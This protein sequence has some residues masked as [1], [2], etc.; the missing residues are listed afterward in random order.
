MEENLPQPQTPVNP[1]QIPVPPAEPP[2][3]QPIPK[4]SFPLKWILIIV[5]LAEIV[6]AGIYLIFKSQ[7][8]KQ[9]PVQAPTQIP[10][11]SFSPAP[12]DKTSNWK[13]Y[14]NNKYQFSISYPENLS[15]KEE[16]HDFLGSQ[17]YFLDE[18]E[19]TP[20]GIKVSAIVYDKALGK[21]IDQDFDTL[22]AL[23]P[24]TSKTITNSVVG[25]NK[26][27]KVQNRTVGGKLAFDY[28]RN[29]LPID[30]VNP[31]V[32]VGTY[33]DLSTSILI[34]E[35]AEADR[36]LLDQMLGTFK[37]LDTTSSPKPTE[38]QFCG[39]I[40]GKVCPTGYK[41]QLDG[42]YPDAGGKCVKE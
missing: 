15:V 42:S 22:Y 30:T 17:I 36:S 5:L 7:S 16:P 25:S 38:G 9:N 33:I 2:V 19:A 1:V 41:C 37:L 23:L 18:K 6:L 12:A 11:T 28:I 8:V 39:G 40:A 3:E 31:E 26:L 21:T 34:L 29:S 14:I 20:S 4:K 24:S 35:A 32:G 13:T 27:T 10:Q